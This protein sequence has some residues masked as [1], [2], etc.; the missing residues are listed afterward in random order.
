MLSP[1]GI[2]ATQD[3]C[4]NGKVIIRP[5]RIRNSTEMTYFKLLI[6]TKHNFEINGKQSNFRM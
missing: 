5:T 6:Y 3:T 1:K 4:I 2:K